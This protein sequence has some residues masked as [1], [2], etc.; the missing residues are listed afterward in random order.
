M[1]VVERSFNAQVGTALMPFEAGRVIEDAVLEKVLLENGSPVTLVSGKSDLI[2]CPHCR[3]A[4][5]I[6]KAV[7]EE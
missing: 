4:F 1:I 7:A 3:R 6:A 2:A 5:T